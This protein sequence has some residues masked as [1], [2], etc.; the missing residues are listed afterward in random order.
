MKIE[1][2]HLNYAYKDKPALQDITLSMQSH[3]MVTILG[4]NGSGKSTLFY[5]LLGFISPQKGEIEVDGKFLS[6]E[7]KESW[8]SKIGYVSQ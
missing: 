3:D 6:E 2:N 7:Y 4:P 5:L 8:R 1:I